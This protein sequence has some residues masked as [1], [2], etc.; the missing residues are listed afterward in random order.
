MDEADIYKVEEMVSE[1]RRL[2]ERIVSLENSLSYLNNSLDVI[3]ERILQLEDKL[4]ET[5]N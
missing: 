4:N 2:K 1:N 3:R 5:I